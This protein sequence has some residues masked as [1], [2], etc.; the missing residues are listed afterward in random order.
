MAAELSLID[1]TEHSRCSGKKMPM[2]V[3]KKPF[4]YLNLNRKQG[5]RLI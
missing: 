2:R 4:P 3:R 1:V 5:A